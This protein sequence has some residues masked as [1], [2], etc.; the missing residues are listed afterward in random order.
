MDVTVSMPFR[1]FQKNTKFD[2]IP[3][4]IENTFYLG[5]KLNYSPR[6]RLVLNFIIELLKRTVI[7]L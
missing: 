4:G 6:D 2:P 5:L 7:Y 3:R 1:V